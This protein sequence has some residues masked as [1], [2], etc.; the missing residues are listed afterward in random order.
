[1]LAEASGID[2][3]SV[4][5]VHKLKGHN[6]IKSDLKAVGLGDDEIGAG[7]AKGARAGPF[8]EGGA[9][10]M[11]HKK[12]GRQLSP[13]RS[14]GSGSAIQALGYNSAAQYEKHTLLATIAKEED[15]IERLRMQVAAKNG[16]IK[17]HARSAA[18]AA[19]GHGGGG[20]GAS[21][22]GQVLSQRQQL[23]AEVSR[24]QRE[25]A[26]LETQ[27]HL[28][29]SARSLQQQSLASA[30]VSDV[31]GSRGA[32]EVH[33]TQAYRCGVHPF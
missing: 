5:R 30:L 9:L 7:D 8:K 12:W 32:G 24:E 3:N 10:G 11:P 15:T 20:V 19:G 16:G 33:G 14:F 17:P 6:R 4:K 2:C 23:E 13:R 21:A 18:A 26:S 29:P 22:G 27:V 31:R 1:M 28:P 25:M